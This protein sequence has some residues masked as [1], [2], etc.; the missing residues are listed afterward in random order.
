MI[1]AAAGGF[2]RCSF[3]T[4]ELT[5]VVGAGHPLAHADACQVPVGHAGLVR[6]V[7]AFQLPDALVVSGDLVHPR[8]LQEHCNV[9]KT[10]VLFVEGRYS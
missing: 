10:G 3:A 1:F 6:V 7:S 8:I 2:H 5:S 9:G 4:D